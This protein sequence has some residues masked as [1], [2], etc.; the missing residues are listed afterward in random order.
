MLFPPSACLSPTLPEW[1]CFLTASCQEGPGN[2]PHEGA[3]GPPR[4]AKDTK[5]THT[6]A[7]ANTSTGTGA[8]TRIDTLQGLRECV[9][10]P[11]RVGCYLF[12]SLSCSREAT[13]AGSCKHGE[14]RASVRRN[15]GNN[16]WSPH[17]S[18]RTTCGMP[19][20][21]SP[22]VQG[23]TAL[24][25]ET[26]RRPSRDGN[27]TKGND[28]ARRGFGDVAGECKPP[29]RRHKGRADLIPRHDKLIFVLS[30][31]LW[32]NIN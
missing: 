30:Y 5:H 23:S 26:R 20:Q 9:R 29:F 24:T 13:S 18:A 22:H 27:E 14:T 21:T 32:L 1:E 12:I 2:Q 4:D 28:S 10:Q 15:P 7:R 8:S 25:A 11:E 17:I 16:K 31:L 19:A 6:H 3:P